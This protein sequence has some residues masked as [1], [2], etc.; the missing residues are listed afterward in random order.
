MKLFPLRTSF[1]Q[2]GNVT[3]A[4]LLWN[5]LFPPVLG[6]LLKYMSEDVPVAAYTLL[7]P[8]VNVSR[9]IIPD[10][11]LLAPPCMLTIRATTVTSP[12]HGRFAKLN[13]SA[14]LQMYCPEAFTVNVPL[15]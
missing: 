9:I 3:L 8:G 13:P 10:D 1:T 5:E 14:V 2:Y 7:D 15:A 4:A 11:W 12:V 6:R